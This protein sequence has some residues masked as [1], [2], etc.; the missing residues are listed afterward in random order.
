MCLKLSSLSSASSPHLGGA[1]LRLTS[2]LKHKGKLCPVLETSRLS[3]LAACGDAIS[4][5]SCASVGTPILLG[6]FF[7]CYLL[8]AKKTQKSINKHIKSVFF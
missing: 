6:L 8:F 3:F 1:L 7:R 5:Y 4:H 2:F